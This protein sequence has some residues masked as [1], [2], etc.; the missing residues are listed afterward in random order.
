MV[1]DRLRKLLRPDARVP[2]GAFLLRIA[3][4]RSSETIDL[5]A[6]ETKAEF[7][8]EWTEQLFALGHSLYLRHLSNSRMMEKLHTRIVE[9]VVQITNNDAIIVVK[10]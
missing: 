2:A 1:D 10:E 6:M 7:L 4:R 9:G 8:Q 3:K 5:V